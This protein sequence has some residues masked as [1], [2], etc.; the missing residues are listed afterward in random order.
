MIFVNAGGVVIL[1][2]KDHTGG[3]QFW[4][5]GRAAEI[6]GSGKTGIDVGAWPIEKGHAGIDIAAGRARFQEIKRPIGGQG[7]FHTHGESANRT[8]AIGAGGGCFT[9]SGGAI[10]I[11]GRDNDAANAR[12]REVAGVALLQAIGIVV[13]KDNTG[14]RT[15]GAGGGLGNREE[16]TV[17]AHDLVQK[18]Q[19]ERLNN[20]LTLS[21]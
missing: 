3:R 14:N 16:A 11:I 1:F 4:R 20:K 2:P 17:G 21:R 12:F 15:A 5:R 7:E 6:S 9:R 19:Q 10:G 18:Y 8:N 13:A